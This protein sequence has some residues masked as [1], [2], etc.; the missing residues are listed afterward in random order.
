MEDKTLAPQHESLNALSVDELVQLRHALIDDNSTQLLRKLDEHV[1]DLATSN[2]GRAADIFD[3]LAASDT[4]DD[5]DA[6]AI[7]IGPL[8]STLP[9]RAETVLLTLLQDSD[10]NIRTTAFETLEDLVE[11]DIL[12]VDDSARLT[13]VFHTANAT[14]TT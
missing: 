14:S 3:A 2:S 13:R 4:Y 9:D 10:D 8:F 1:R 6:A 7:Y 11:H 12:T 5:R